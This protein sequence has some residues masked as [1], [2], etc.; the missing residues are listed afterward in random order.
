MLQNWYPSPSLV[1]EQRTAPFFKQG[2]FLTVDQVLLVLPP[3]YSQ[4]RILLILSMVPIPANPCVIS[5]LDLNYHST[6]SGDPE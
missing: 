5:C 1:V 2:I 6:Y 3:E 4:N